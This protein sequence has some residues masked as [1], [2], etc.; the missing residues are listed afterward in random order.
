MTLVTKPRHMTSLSPLNA[1]VSS[2]SKPKSTPPR[3]LP[4]ATDTPAAAAAA[5][6][7]RFWADGRL[8]WG[9]RTN[10]EMY[11]H[12]HC[13]VVGIF[14]KGETPYSTRHEQEDPVRTSVGDI[15]H[16]I[17]EHT[18]LPNDRPEATA[19]ARPSALMRSVQGLRKASNT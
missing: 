8:V 2:S 6:S 10:R 13:V 18:S 19:K 12:I 17:Q 9:T 14:L 16:F 1:K 3:G 7:L 4:N 15:S 5:R 11:T